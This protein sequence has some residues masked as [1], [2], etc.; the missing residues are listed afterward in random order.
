MSGF[1]RFAAV[2]G[3]FLGLGQTERQE[4]ELEDELRFHIEM[5]TE[6]NLRRGMTSE[7]AR[8]RAV[9]LFGGV[10]GHKEASRDLRRVHTLDDLARGVRYTVR[11]LRRA[12]LAALTIV[13]TVGLGLGL[14]AAVFTILNAYIFRADEVREP[15]ELFA[16]ERERSAN[17]APDP[18][19]H[20][21]YEALLRETSIFT[22]AFATTQ[23]T[24]AWIEGRRMEGPLVT[25]NFFH[26]LGAAAALGRVLTPADDE[27]GSPPAIVLSHLTWTRE[28]AR[29]PGLIGGTVRVNG[30]PF[31]VVGVMPEGFRGLAPVAA[32][33]FWVPLSLLNE[34]GRTEGIS[35]DEAGLE[36]V[37]RLNPGLAP[38]QAIAELRAWDASQAAERF[39]DRPAAT[40]NLA[41]R[42][43]TIPLSAETMLMFTPIFF[44]FGLIL[45]IGCANVANLLFARG[46]ARQRE[47]GIRLALGA[48]RG[49]LVW[50]LLT[51]SL[52]LALISAALAF[53]IARG[54][55][56][57][58]VYAV[59]STFPP[60]LG[61]LRLAIPP[62]DWRVVLFLLA[63]A[64]ASTLFFALAP[65]L[66]AT[67]LELVRAIRGEVVRDARPGRTRDALIT[68]Q[69]TGSALL[70]ICAVVF[71]RGSR[72]AA[73]VDP[74][75]RTA[76]IVNVSVLNE[77]R[78]GAILDIVESEPIVASVAA[79]SPS[80]LYGLP[81]FVDGAGAGANGGT[82]V[83][84]QY[85][86]PE[87]F[88]IL[89]IDLV[90][91]RGFTPAE[92]GADAGVA[93]V[94]ES[95]ARELW[96]GADAVGQLLRLEPDPTILAESRDDPPALP[97]AAVVIGIA[98]DVAGFRLGGFRMSGADVYMPIDLDAP[99]ALLTMRV[100]AD[101]ER[102][103]HVL[104]DQ[105][106][107]IDPNMAEVETLRAMANAEAYLLG[108]PFWLTL[109]LG[110]LALLLTLSG[111]FS[112]ISYLVERR[113]REI[114]VRMALGATRRGIAALV[115]SQSI[116]P[117]GIG[118]FL[119]VG[120][121]AAL[122]AVILA[123]PAAEQI[124]TSVRMLDPV[125]YAVGL[126]WIVAACACA[127]LVPTL[128][129]ARID[130][131]GAL[132]QD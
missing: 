78:R 112:V 9:L 84:Y 20:S 5:Q 127:A 60:D 46:V 37:G 62:A 57:G 97:G 52:F 18:F 101:P 111:L 24:D 70:L 12:P 129:A 71:L 107:A 79:A 39:G 38:G 108:I 10:E 22:D 3:R 106:A 94:S 29:D 48:S 85:V 98:R 132:R 41:P 40:L 64:I 104:V 51:E 119:G 92:R 91:G 31:R 69:V 54:V 35:V 115:I 82:A 45:L 124:G 72:E 80:L 17:L 4:V 90:R 93:V 50:Q 2:V 125:A 56:R 87:Y 59:T 30:T 100:L 76:D 28:F 14:V 123:T 58:V 110:G 120:F 96:P 88:G 27:P 83:R 117:V 86:S 11:S 67:R 68:I 66:Q 36:I 23:A 121:T 53:G 43:G 8:R 61:D 42:Q 49:R 15:H 105:F 26:V 34:I 109:M 7:D 114:G 126:F 47:L 63:G 128:R 77:Q 21:S 16:V 103:R 89:G 116:R 130:P 44:A 32:P 131:A 6:E 122:G 13:A 99:G 33:D 113:S 102:A 95:T 74:G 55:L 65:A 25:G 19:T 73:A 118:L 81:A 1:R 75:I